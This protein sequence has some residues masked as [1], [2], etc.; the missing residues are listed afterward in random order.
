MKFISVVGLSLAAAALPY[1]T[2]GIFSTTGTDMLPI[3]TGNLVF[4]GLVSNTVNAPSNISFGTFDASGT[5]AGPISSGETFILTITQVSPT[6]GTAAASATLSGS[7]DP[8]SS[9]VLLSF[10]NTSFN[11]GGTDYTIAQPAGGYPI[12]PASSN[13]GLVTIEGTAAVPEPGTYLGIGSGLALMA[14]GSR[15]RRTR[16]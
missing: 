1:S 6:S 9:S 2:T 7:I 10:N 4:D 3:G 11:I 8:S 15:R 16:A 14:I 13:K 12:V 5:G